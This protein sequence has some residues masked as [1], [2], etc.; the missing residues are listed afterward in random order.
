ML[1]I[2]T[3][4]SKAWLLSTCINS[5]IYFIMF[6]VFTFSQ[7]A[8]KTTIVSKHFVRCA[9]AMVLNTAFVSLHFPPCCRG[10]PWFYFSLHEELC[11]VVVQRE[12]HPGSTSS[13]TWLVDT[14]ECHWRAH[15]VPAKYQTGYLEDFGF[16][17]VMKCEFHDHP[18]E[19]RWDSVW[20]RLSNWEF[21]SNVVV[22][23]GT[24]W[25][26]WRQI[27]CSLVHTYPWFRLCLCCRSP[28]LLSSFR[29]QLWLLTQW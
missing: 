21:I 19:V 22:Q 3:C 8:N 15:C 1:Y 11:E 26:L 14:L 9:G 4:S 12:L 2:H 20:L 18:D 10:I 25:G 5:S 7:W 28:V 29:I 6:F 17:H 24:R 13:C 16:G 27:F 23:P